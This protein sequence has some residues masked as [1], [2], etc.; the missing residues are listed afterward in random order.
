MTWI[1]KRTQIAQGTQS[2]E[3]SDQEKIVQECA[4]GWLYV[5]DAA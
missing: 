5:V 4:S 1:V 3:A 2:L